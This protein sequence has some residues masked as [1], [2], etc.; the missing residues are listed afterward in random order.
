MP[1]AIGIT[2]IRHSCHLIEI[3]GRT[4]LTDPWFTMKAHYR[5]GEPTAV[6]V[7]GLPDLDGVLISH[8]H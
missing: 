3:G 5:P 8:E 2:R 6:D 7:A 4:L 1:P